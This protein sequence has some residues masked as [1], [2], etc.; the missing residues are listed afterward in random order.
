M[1]ISYFNASNGHNINDF[2]YNLK[3][4]FNG[5]IVFVCIGTDA[6]ILDSFGPMVGT[7]LKQKNPNLIIYGT[8]D[9]PITA[10][11]LKD[12]K[13]YISKKHSKSIIIAIDAA[14][15]D[16]SEDVHRVILNDTPIKPGEAFNKKL[17]KIGTYSIKGITGHTNN[18]I[19]NGRI[20]YIYKMA[21]QVA[22]II[23]DSL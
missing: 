2:K 6:L 3:S 13:K 21:E 5:D 12:K 1:S 11:N 16:N 22:N 10:L 7:M 19:S 14:L 4:L 18:N 9:D 20:R 8:L 17:P 15:S 23:I